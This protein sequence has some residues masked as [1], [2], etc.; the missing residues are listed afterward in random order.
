MG[1]WQKGCGGQ[2]VCI[3]FLGAVV[4]ISW[5]I[6]E[7]RLGGLE[8]EAGKTP[9][10]EWGWVGQVCV[11]GWTRAC[12]GGGAVVRLETVEPRVKGDS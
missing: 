8:W 9:G 1:R 2:V 5:G 3:A 7:K 4:L 12:V 6:G 11:A 10:F